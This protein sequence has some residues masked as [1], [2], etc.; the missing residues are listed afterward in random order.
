M[1]IDR[2]G[3]I[4]SRATKL[5]RKGINLESPDKVNSELADKAN[6]L[7]GELA[8]LFPKVDEKTQKM[9]KTKT[10]GLSLEH[11]GDS[12]LRIFCV[13]IDHSAGKYRVTQGDVCIVDNLVTGVSFVEAIGSMLS[14]GMKAGEKVV[15]KDIETLMRKAKLTGVIKPHK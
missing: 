5:K 6:H 1:V 2:V 12:E 13:F 15:V 9:I 4:P 8:Q 10:A 11:E 7:L 14:A 3:S